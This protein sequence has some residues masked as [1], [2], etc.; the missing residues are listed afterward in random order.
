M[1]YTVPNFIRQ[2]IQGVIEETFGTTGGV[3]AVVVATAD[4]FDVATLS[5]GGAS[6]TRVAATA[7]SI[8]AIGQAV[9]RETGL[10]ANRM[11]TLD[12]EQ[13]FVVVAST[14]HDGLDLVVSVVASKD[15]VLGQIN[16]RITQLN[17]KLAN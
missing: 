15:A 1:S 11:V 16:Y 3:R 6:A 17:Q 12:C 10:G 13:G 8:A 2:K 5:P 9:G 14:R 7:S 4:G